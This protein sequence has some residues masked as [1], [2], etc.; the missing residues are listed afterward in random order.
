MLRDVTLGNDS[1]RS[2]LCIDR[3]EWAEAPDEEQELVNPVN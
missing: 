2:S 1:S 3:F